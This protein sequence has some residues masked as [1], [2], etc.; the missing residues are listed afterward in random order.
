MAGQ[1]RAGRTLSG[2]PTVSLRADSLDQLTPPPLDGSAGFVEVDAV[3][4][5]VGQRASTVRLTVPR[6]QAWRFRA[7]SFLQRWRVSLAMVA[8]ALALLTALGWRNLDLADAVI[9]V[10]TVVLLLLPEMLIKPIG[11]PV[12]VAE[13]VELPGVDA[14]VADKWRE[15]NPPG[16]V[17]VRPDAESVKRGFWWWVGGLALSAFAV[18][19]TASVNWVFLDEPRQVV[20]TREEY[21]A[22]YSDHRQFRYIPSGKDLVVTGMCASVGGDTSAGVRLTPMRD[23]VTADPGPGSRSVPCDGQ[24]HTVTLSNLDP[25]TSLLRF[26]TIGAVSGWRLEVASK[27]V[28][29]IRVPLPVSP[30]TVVIPLVVTALGVLILI[31]LWR[32]RWIVGLVLCA[33]PLALAVFSFWQMWAQAAL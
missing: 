10:A 30:V 18:L 19:G 6:A 20:A 11:Y 9:G 31:N 22:Q 3:V 26:E 29:T 14:A 33:A 16:L 15:L 2:M 32:L 4:R 24:R 23:P 27:E 1:L 25:A 12:K 28:V 17:E 5:P 13:C 8:A 21:V 7:V